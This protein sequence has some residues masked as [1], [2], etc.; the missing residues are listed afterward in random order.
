MRVL[1]CGGRTFG[2]YVGHEPQ[3][4]LQRALAQELFFNVTLN[5][6]LLPD[7]G[8]SSSMLAGGARGADTLARKWAEYWNI[9]FT[10]YP[11]DWKT[12]GKSAG[13]IRN[14]RMLFEGQPDLVI[15][16][17]GG[18]GTEDMV[19]KAKRAGVSVKRI[20]YGENI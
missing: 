2:H 1:I 9:P 19:R 5:G 14:Q 13:S 4:V 17:P 15:A 20:T 10:E 18:A 3:E 16:F 11:A 12:H 8:E 7:I 6:L